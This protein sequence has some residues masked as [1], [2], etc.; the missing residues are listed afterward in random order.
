MRI[1]ICD[2]NPVQAG[3]LQKIVSGW[4]EQRGVRACV[5][6]YP[7]AEAFLFEYAE[8]MSV[9]ILL[10]DILLSGMNGVELARRIRESDAHPQIV[11]ITAYSDFVAD[12][13][14]VDAL[15]YLMKP[16]E[17]EKLCEVLD[18]A[19]K[20][21]SKAEPSVMLE[22]EEGIVR[23]LEK[24][25]IYAEAFSHIVCVKCICGDLTVKTPISELETQ[26]GESFVRCHRSYL[27]GLRHIRQ[28]TRTDVIL[29]DGGKLPLS[30][31]NY[32]A[33]NRKFISFY[34]VK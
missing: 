15:H 18:K 7:S 12:G 9:D 2:D 31:R 23:L 4:I 25:I 33:V 13:Y 11:F 14:D 30:R 1:A 17:P 8:N 3:N 32:D 24:D 16:I 28:I 6:K 21:L 27:V 26:L 10:L 20:S 19:V 5:T 29:D 22:T 34:R